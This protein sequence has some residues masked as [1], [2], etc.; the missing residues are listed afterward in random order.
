MKSESGR[1]PISE[2]FMTENLVLALPKGRIL[3]EAIP[4]LARAGIEPENYSECGENCILTRM[5]NFE[6]Q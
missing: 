2:I 1:R 5:W 3:K 4:L 6:K